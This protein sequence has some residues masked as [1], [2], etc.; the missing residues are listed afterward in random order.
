MVM[1]KGEYPNNEEGSI[2][3]PFFRRRKYENIF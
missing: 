2:A 3:E 1:V